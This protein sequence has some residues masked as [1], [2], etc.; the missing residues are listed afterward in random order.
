MIETQPGLAYFV[1][2]RPAELSGIPCNEHRSG[3]MV[4]F[5][6]KTLWQFG[7]WRVAQVCSSPVQL[8]QVFRPD[9]VGDMV[10]HCDFVRPFGMDRL[11]PEELGSLQP[12]IKR[13]RSE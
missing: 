1:C 12:F 5:D 4:R 9:S 7:P 8:G 13:P 6:N 10:P 11:A 2:F 3:Q